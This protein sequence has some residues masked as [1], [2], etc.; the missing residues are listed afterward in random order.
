MN[1]FILDEDPVKAAQMHCNKHVIKM[2]LES[3]QML[4]AAHH[5]AGEGDYKDQL[6]KMTH[7]NHPCTEWAYVASG[8]YIWLFNL[9]RALLDEYEYR[10]GR[11]HE[12]SK[13]VPLLEKKPKWISDSVRSPFR[14][15][16]SND[17][18]IS[19]RENAVEAYR[20]YYKLKSQ[21]MTMEWPPERV[22]DWW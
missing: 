3:A 1:I 9:F 2:I 15:A 19:N 10:Y 11:V 20:E 12:S 21:Q 13:L 7:R 14:I 22:P 6:Y 16:I 8:N 4:S 18:D 17:Y 5:I